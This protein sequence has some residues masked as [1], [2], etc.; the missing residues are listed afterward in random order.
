MEPLHFWN[1]HRIVCGA[2][3]IYTLKGETISFW[4]MNPRNQVLM[5]SCRSQIWRKYLDKSREY[6]VNQQ[7]PNIMTEL[8]HAMYPKVSIQNWSTIRPVEILQISLGTKGYLN[9]SP[10]FPWW[11]KMENST[12][13][14]SVSDR[15][16]CVDLSGKTPVCY[17]V[18]GK[19]S[20][21]QGSSVRDLS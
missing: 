19:M 8:E 1:R 20:A 14:L 18:R 5:Q 16:T 10:E 3:L 9:S 6:S 15:I 21:G 11:K 13:G 12:A 2:I 17:T 7:G 4:Q